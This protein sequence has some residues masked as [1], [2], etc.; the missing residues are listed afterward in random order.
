MASAKLKESVHRVIATCNNP[1]R[2]GA[3]RLNKILWFSDCEAYR[4]NGTSI[5]GERYIKRQLGPVPARILEAIRELQGED[6]IA[7]KDAPHYNSTMRH[8]FSLND[9]TP[10]TLSPQDIELLDSY[11][12]VICENYTA[13]GISNVSHDNVW[14]AAVMGEEIPLYTIFAS[15]P[16]TVTEDVQAW[17]SSIIESA[18]ENRA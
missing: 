5:T 13:L 2:L 9:A 16:G 17:A 4:Q 11:T 7:V 18:L 1:A 15:N 10:E 6:T 12:N 14:E 8:F 3:V